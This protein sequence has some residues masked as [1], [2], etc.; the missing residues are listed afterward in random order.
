[1]NSSMLLILSLYTLLFPI[2]I[3]DILEDQ[4]QAVQ[5]ADCFIT[6]LHD[7][8]GMGA[9]MRHVMTSALV[10]PQV[11]TIGIGGQLVNK[12][13]IIYLCFGSL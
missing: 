11:C 1:M 2:S 9:A 5:D 7:Y 10:N 4:L 12:L 6:M 8:S 3:P 13:E